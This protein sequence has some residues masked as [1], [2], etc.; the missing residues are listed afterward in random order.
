M[1]CRATDGESLMMG[2][3]QF[4]GSHPGCV[5]KSHADAV[6]A[7]RARS[8][9]RLY[10]MRVM[11]PEG[12]M[13]VNAATTRAAEKG[14]AGRENTSKSAVIA[15]AGVIGLATA[16]RLLHRGFEVTV[17]DAEPVSGASFAAAGMLAP[18]A[19][20]VWDQPTLYPLMVESGKLYRDFALAIAEESG[21]DV[22]YIENST[23]VCAGDSADRQTLSELVELQHDLGMNITRITATQARRAEPALGPGCVGAVDIPGDHQINPRMLAD[24]L[25]TILGD[26]VV[27]TNAAEIIYAEGSSRA[28]GLRGEDGTDYLADEVVLAAGLK[29]G[30]IAGLPEN[31]N[32]PLRP[33]YGDI[34]R[35]RVPERLQ[36]LVTRTIRGVVQGRPVYIVP[37]ADG[38]VVLG[39]TSRE[40]DMTGV[41][42]EGVH[43]LLR[44]AYRLVPGILDCE[45]YEM[46]AR[47]RPGSPDDVP[48]IGRIVPGLTVSTGYFR[49]G[50]LLTAIGSKITAEIVAGDTSATDSALIRAVNP[51]RFSV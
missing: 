24:A 50:I 21:Q 14:Q 32:L 18:V 29:T 43:Q 27:R 39:A 34:L 46:T 15:G 31:L 51:F 42:A 1:R 13:A 16:W 38:T 44:D 28:V 12:G 10:L 2:E 3:Y 8:A 41:S 37:R 49:H 48:M 40:D 17:L 26:R 19:E 45:I 22:G 20:V 35:L 30:A 7:E 47:A 25:L 11:P 36:P 23:F 4:R 33:V 9:D 6:V 5:G